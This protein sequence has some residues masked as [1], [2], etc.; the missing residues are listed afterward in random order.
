M[1]N[2]SLDDCRLL[3]DAPSFRIYAQR[4]V[5]N[6][7]NGPSLTTYKCWFYLVPRAGVE[8]LGSGLDPEL[9][10]EGREMAMNFS[11]AAGFCKQRKLNVLS[12]RAR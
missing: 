12:D 10:S 4:T 6:A 8:H 5:K 1:F 7:V 11:R 2:Q 3:I 9:T